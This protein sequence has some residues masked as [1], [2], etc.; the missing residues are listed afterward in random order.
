M[1][2]ANSVA[3]LSV[4]AADYHTNQ[5]SAKIFSKTVSVATNQRTELVRLTDEIRSFVE[6]TGVTDG[7]AQI[8]SLHTTA[9]LFVNEW[10]EALL[11]DIKS[12]FERVIPRELY[13]RHNDPLHSD[14]DRRNADSHLCN[15][16]LNQSLSIPV[17]QG[18]LM[19]GQWQNVI[20]AE[21]DGPNLRKVF[22]QVFGI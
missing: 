3:Q 9:G 14:C 19:L 4:P 11:T 13:Y 5:G 22:L 6:Q 2:V 21:F 16:I 12:M 20:L 7:F 18:R 1:E 15:L 17:E 10:Q 8:S